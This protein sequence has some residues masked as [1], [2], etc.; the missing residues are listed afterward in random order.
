MKCTVTSERVVKASRPRQLDE[1]LQ[2]SPF[3]DV[4]PVLYSQVARTPIECEDTLVTFVMK[5]L[6]KIRGDIN[7]QLDSIAP[8][9]RLSTSKSFR[10]FHDEGNADIL[11]CW[12]V[13]V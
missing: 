7:G 10:N 4:M 9:A 12:W 13:Q 8:P 1:T 6:E 11:I 5:I 3:D 2:L